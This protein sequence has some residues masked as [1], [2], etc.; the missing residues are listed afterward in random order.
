MA[1]TPPLFAVDRMLGRLAVWLRLLGYDATCGPHLAG[2]TLL[3]QARLE[4]RIVVTRDRQLRREHNLPPL[5][6]IESDHFR[7]Q[8]RQVVAAYNLDPSAHIFTRCSR[9]NEPV[10]PIDKAQVSGQVPE[11]VIATQE[12]FVRCA[13]CRRIYWPATHYTRVRDEVERLRFPTGVSA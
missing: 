7:D 6:F 8:L 2:R 13:R 5:L 12:H 1:S 10:V 9:C 3:R 11:Y 4:R